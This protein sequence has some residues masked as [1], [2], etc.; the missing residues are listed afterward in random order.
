MEHPLCFVH[1]ELRQS[2]QLVLGHVACLRQGKGRVSC[3]EVGFRRYP[4]IPYHSRTSFFLLPCCG[5]WSV[6]SVQFWAAEAKVC[7]DNCS[8]S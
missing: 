6:S 4:L 7:W 1:G 8:F 3:F 5:S 2:Q